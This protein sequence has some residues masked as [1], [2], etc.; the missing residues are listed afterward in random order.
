[1]KTAKFSFF[2]RNKKNVANQWPIVLSIT[3]NNDRTQLFTG[4]YTVL[5]P[6]KTGDIFRNRLT[7]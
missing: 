2:L 4:L 6:K 7:Y 5:A 3:V 1:M